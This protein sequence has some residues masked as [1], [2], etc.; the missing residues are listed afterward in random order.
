M[1]SD[2]CISITD[3]RK[4]AGKHLKNPKKVKYVFFNN[5][6][7]SA[8]V[9]MKF[10]EKFE[11]LEKLQ[12]RLEYIKEL[13]ASLDDPENTKYWP[14]EADEFIKLLENNFEWDENYRN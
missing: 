7:E 10:I 12:K 6:P 8:I 14:F 13:E 1:T 3:I 5:K 9:P 2:Q 11:E 4:N